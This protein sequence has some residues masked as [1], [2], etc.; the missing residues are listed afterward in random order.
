MMPLDAL[1]HDV[2]PPQAA[3]FVSTCFQ[4][5]F[6]DSPVRK[7]LITSTSFF[8]IALNHGYDR[9]YYKIFSFAA[10][11]CP[12]ILQHEIGKTPFPDAGWL[13]ASP[14]KY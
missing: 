8:V 6:S 10:C 5:Y 12:N 3:F 9:R 4:F 14:G 7:E 2:V 1:S 11:S 13:T